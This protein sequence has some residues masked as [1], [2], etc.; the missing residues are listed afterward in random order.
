MTTAQ[1]FAQAECGATARAGRDLARRTDLF[2]KHPWEV[3]FAAGGTDYASHE[4]MA[5]QRFVLD[6]SVEHLLHKMWESGFSVGPD[7]TVQPGTRV[8]IRDE[9][10]RVS[11]FVAT[12]PFRPAALHNEYRIVKQEG[13]EK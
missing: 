13:T 5:G 4:W 12:G 8:L 9:V 6:P 10:G 11:T 1:E 3:T 2:P 7:Y